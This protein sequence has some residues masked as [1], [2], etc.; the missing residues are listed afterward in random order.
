[1]LAVS[2]STKHTE[3]ASEYAVAITDKSVASETLAGNAFSFRDDSLAGLRKLRVA[4][5]HDWLTAYAG[6]EKVLEQILQL[7]PQAEL[8][9]LVDHLPVAQR[10]FIAGR[11]IHTSFLQ[12][13]PFS[14][15]LFRK[16]LWLFPLAIE[17]FDL[18]PFDLVLSSSHA[19][20]KGVITGPDQLHICY[21][22]SPI[23][24]A[25]DCQHEYL[26]QAGLDAGLKSIYAR[27]A[28]HYLRLW[29]V[30]TASGVD[31]FIANSSF[32]ARRIRKAYSRPATVIHPPVDVDKFP[33]TT[34]KSDYYVTA[35]RLV[36][37]KRVDLIVQAFAK[38]PDRR[39]LVIG[40]GPEMRS[41]QKLAASNV[42]MLGYQTD[43]VLRAT[44][45]KA[46]AF[47]FAAEEDFGI[48]VVEAQACGTPVI[49]YGKGGVLDSVIDRETGIYFPEQSVESIVSAVERFEALTVPLSPFKIRAQAQRF[50]P[51][52]FQN[53]FARNVALM[54]KEHCI[55][56]RGMAQA[57]EGLAM[58]A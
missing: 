12:R 7:F 51:E 42:Q 41:C 5:V 35:S 1:L 19:V 21:C 18:S 45:G 2:Q 54:W 55:H 29:D 15:Q 10:P 33:L 38:M 39:L 17:S 27:T 11:T 53:K 9:T 32:I 30:R 28:L 6:S 58:S 47:I 50:S 24:Y 22:H 36:P 4:V 14:A 49:C 43:E 23:R 31:Q 8:F 48:S 26:R 46:R 57:S 37:Y 16:L 44:L 20:A 25:W 52:Q 13:L 40:D 34:Q 56:I 3:I